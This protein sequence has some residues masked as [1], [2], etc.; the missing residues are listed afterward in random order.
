MSMA[1]P[2]EPAKPKLLTPAMLREL[3]VRSDRQGAA[4]SLGHYAEIIVMGALIWAVA[5]RYGVIWTLPLMV[6]Q[7]VFV[8]F[9]F[10][11]VH[12]TAH[13]TA[14]ASH[15]LNI[16]VGY[17]SG[18][19]IGLPY[20]YYCLFHWEHHRHTQDPEKDPE[21]IVGPKPRSDAQLAIAYS[22]LQQ[23]AGR[24]SLMLRHALGTVT[25]P[26]VPTGRRSVIVRE[27]RCY[28]ALYAL[29]DATPPAA[30]STTPERP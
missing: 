16:L 7:G 30:P 11:A 4:R 24:L 12:E 8:A 13:K 26:W 3:S 5:S 6:V 2:I 14:F 18:F 23:V 29:L 9:L 1:S 10:M 25:V 21:L 19:I 15:R 27:A 20:E 22:G 28:V 17:L